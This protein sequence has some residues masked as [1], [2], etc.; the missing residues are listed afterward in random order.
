MHELS[1]AQSILESAKSELIASPELGRLREIG[2]RVGALSGVLPDS[3]EFC[4]DAI[5][6]GSDFDGCRMVIEFLPVRARCNDCHESFTVERIAFSCPK[7]ASG[8]I[9]IKQGF[10]LEIAYLEVD[11]ETNGV[12]YVDENPP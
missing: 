9:E 6:R 2:V 3:L 12:G 4:F 7:C 8:S 5:T 11:E 10:E 1:I